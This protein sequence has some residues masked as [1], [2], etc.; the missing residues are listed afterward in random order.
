MK[1]PRCQAE[2]ADERVSCWKCAAPLKSGAMGVSVTPTPVS[3]APVAA[4]P[5]PIVRERRLPIAA[6]VVP[7]VL[8]IVL[9][10]GGVGALAVLNSPERV[11][12]AFSDALSKGDTV[13]LQ[14]LVTAK[15]REKVAKWKFPSGQS[16]S[17]RFVGLERRGEQLVAK[18]EADIPA[19]QKAQ[20]AAFG[21]QLPDKMDL[22]FALVRERLIFWRVDL[23]KSKPLLNESV[24]KALG[25]QLQ[26]FMQAFIQ[27]FGQVMQQGYRR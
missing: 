2:N 3:R 20:A 17:V 5:H 27:A 6:V 8:V 12:K 25:P 26:Q 10:G 1:C 19:A 23:E 4:P 14:K 16:S 21:L 11:A 9:A 7:I 15:D 22:P 24:M 18:L 13:T